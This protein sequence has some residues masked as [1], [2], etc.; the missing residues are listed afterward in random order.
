VGGAVCVCALVAVGFVN[1]FEAEPG[2]VCCCLTM[3]AV[4]GLDLPPDCCLTVESKGI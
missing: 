4:G 1:V 3:A 2:V